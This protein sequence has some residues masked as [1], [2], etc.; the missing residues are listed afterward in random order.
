MAVLES[1]TARLSRLLTMVPWLVNRQGID[2]DRAAA[3]L[4]VSRAQIEADLNLLFVCGTPGHLPDDLI[5]AEWEEGRVFLRNADTISRPLRLGRD[6][7]M[8]LIVGLRALAAVPGLEEHEAIDRALAKLTEAAGESAGQ[9][10]RVRVALEEPTVRETLETLRS[11][12][13]RRRRVHLRY[14]VASRD[15]ATERDVDP[16]RLVNMT[17][18]W[19]LEGWCHRAEDVRLFRLDRIEEASVLDRDGTPPA[20]AQPRDLESTMFT[21][22]PDDRTATLRLQPE[23]AWV[24]DYYPVE[25]V[26]RADDGALTVQIRTADIAWLRRLVWR[27]GGSARVVAPESMRREVA[28]GAS[29]ALGY[30][31]RKSPTD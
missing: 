22:G 9:S 2:I 30:Y 20:Q 12:L 17:S 21:H 5:E 26:E 16:M 23:A 13:S 11:A 7:A 3:E 4:N 14:L 31:G 27:L 1:A 8:A 19:Y 10:D 29:D 15:E 18:H 25:Q 6:E 24:V 28:R